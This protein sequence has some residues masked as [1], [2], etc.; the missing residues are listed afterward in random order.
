V[1]CALVVLGILICSYL[2][3]HDVVTFTLLASAIS[4]VRFAG[5]TARAALIASV[6]TG[7]DRVRVRARIRVVTNVMVGIGALLAGISLAVGTPLAFGVAVV[8]VGVLTSLSALPL[9]SREIDFSAA[10]AAAKAPV[11][12]KAS[13]PGERPQSP[14][15]DLR[16]LAV[17]F[18]VGVNATYFALLE[19]GMP[20]WVTQHTSAP[21]VLVAVLLATNTAVIVLTQVVA[22]KGCHEVRTAGRAA[23][24]GALL[25]AAACLVFAISG[26]VGV[27]IASALLLLALLLMSGGEAFGE[28]G[29]WGL[30]MELAHPRNQARYQGVAEMA[31]AAGQ[32][33]GPLLISVTALESGA[34][35]WLVLAVMFVASGAGLHLLS[36]TG[37]RPQWRPA[38]PVAPVAV[39]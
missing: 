1:V 22:S 29:A 33:V 21:D 14:F 18:L 9:L 36:R 10:E 19:I 30:T 20:L 24:R 17:S 13:E 25:I 32:T 5:I 2:L 4:A 3:A 7:P 8:L 16:Y 27:L 23:L 12:G 11:A 39:Q 37:G 28:A 6:F 34:R 35:G 26:S 31:Y 15:T 38:E